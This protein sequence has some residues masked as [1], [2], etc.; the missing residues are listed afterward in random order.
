MIHYEVNKGILWAGLE[1]IDKKLIDNHPDLKIIA[2]NTTGTDHVD[3]EYAESKGIKVINLSGEAQNLGHIPSTAEHTFGL[4]LALSRHYKRCFRGERVVGNELYHKKIGVIGHGR[5]GE[6]VLK[7]AMV[8]CMEV[9]LR[10][11]TFPEQ[12]FS[13]P[14]M[15]F[16]S[17]H[18][19][20]NFSTQGMVGKIDFK[21]MKPSAYFINTA[22]RQLVEEGALQWA[23][24]TREIA[25][26]ATDFDEG[27]EHDNLLTTPH[28]GGNTEEGLE[29]SEVYLANMVKEYVN[30]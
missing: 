24:E 27:F 15:D 1:P 21:L 23:L 11:P 28:I 17:L 25:G 30:S 10:D 3:I 14:D 4:M 26:A 12:D 5:I 2:H 6:L 16:V 9:Y 22:R 19:P 7:Y 20:L 13:Y 8:F 18:A 29:K